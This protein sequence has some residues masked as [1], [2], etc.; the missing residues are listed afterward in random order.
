MGYTT[1]KVEI[2]EIDNF[3]IILDREYIY[4]AEFDLG[5]FKERELDLSG[6]PTDSLA[7]KNEMNAK[8][9]GGW[10]HFFN[11][12]GRA[13]HYNSVWD[14]LPGDS[15]L[16]VSF[17]VDQL[18][19]MSEFIFDPY[20]NHLDSIET[21]LKSLK[22]WS[23]ALQNGNP[24]NQFY[25][26]SLKWSESPAIPVGGMHA[27]YYFV[28]DNL[29]YPKKSRNAGV[30]GRVFVEFRVDVDGSIIDIKILR[31]VSADIDEEAMRIISLSP[32]WIPGSKG[33]RP[34][35]QRIILPIT[36][37]VG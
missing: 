37:K 23:P 25:K 11:D 33:G 8:Y 3:K 21:Q 20:L 5:H 31:G 32:K 34:V 18:G 9:P 19:R 28:G 30:Q 22:K 15:V 10:E 12:L 16:K 27:F 2:P 13:L 26:L 24:T 1:S 36:F 6:E 17:T 4:I 14:E 29:R 35:K 7:T